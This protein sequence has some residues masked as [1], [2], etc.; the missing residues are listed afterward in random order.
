[1]ALVRGRPPIVAGHLPLVGVLGFA[2]RGYAEV[3]LAWFVLSFPDERPARRS[4]RLVVAAFLGVC[5]GRAPP[6]GSWAPRPARAT[7]GR[8][9]PTPSCSNHDRATFLWLDVRIEAVAA[10][11][12]LAVAALAIQRL[13]RTGASGRRLLSPVLVGGA[14]GAAGAAA[15]QLLEVAHF[16]V[17]VDLIPWDW[18][19]WS[20][21]SYLVRLVLPVGILNGVSRLRG[22]RAEVVDLV[23]GVDTE[24]GRRHLE[25]ALRAASMTPQIDLLYIGASGE[26]RTRT[27]TRGRCRRPEAWP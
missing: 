16:V 27:A 2:F 3:V 22:R 20:P 18:P 10:L 5:L 19:L 14:V 8:V 15:F 26:W 11:L 9:A 13:L 6:S 7:R 24:A 1:M 12:L 4:E 25:A 21:I 23:I 17:G